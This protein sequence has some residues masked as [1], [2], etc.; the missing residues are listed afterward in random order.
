MHKYYAIYPKSNIR[1]TPHCYYCIMSPVQNSTDY[2]VY[3]LLS[4]AVTTHN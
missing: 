4:L 3:K 1:I 2:P